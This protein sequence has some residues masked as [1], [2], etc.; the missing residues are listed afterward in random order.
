VFLSGYRMMWLMVMFDLPV[1][2]D[3]D[4][5]AASGF[6]NFLLEEGFSMNQYSVYFRLASGKEVMERE[7]RAIKLALPPHGKVDIITI[8]DRQYESI[9]SYWNHQAQPPKQTPDQL[10]L[11]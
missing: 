6:R 7:Q 5:K 11:L 10:F 3:D 8:T 4:R 1:V 2:N 9:V